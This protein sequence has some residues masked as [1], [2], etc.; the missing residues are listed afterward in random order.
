MASNSLSPGRCR[1]GRRT[2]GRTGRV[3]GC[4]LA[5][6]R[7]NRA[8]LAET[9]LRGQLVDVLDISVHPIVAGSDGL[10]FR[11]GQDVD[12][13]LVAVKTFS[14]IVKLTFEPRYAEGGQGP[15][16]RNR[17]GPDTGLT[18]QRE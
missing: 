10:L 7:L 11:A 3:G 12:M 8:R 4:W 5:G 1:T 18:V 2:H 13:K 6:L 15:A 9:L 17:S 16:R 14:E